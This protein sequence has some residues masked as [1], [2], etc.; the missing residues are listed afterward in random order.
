MVIPGSIPEAVHEVVIRTQRRKLIRR[1]AAD[2]RDKNRVGRKDFPD[3]D[4]QTESGIRTV[5]EKS[6]KDNGAQDLGLM[7]CRPPSCRIKLERYS[8][9][10]SR[11]RDMSL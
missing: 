8:P 4:S 1:A 6:E 3:P 5:K 10:V 11:L 2:Q 7:A 9:T